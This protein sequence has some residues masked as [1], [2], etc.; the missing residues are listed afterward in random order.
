MA[1]TRFVLRELAG[2]AGIEARLARIAAHPNPAWAPERDG[3]QT[4]ID[5]VSRALF[6]ITEEETRFEVE[7]ETAPISPGPGTLDA[8]RYE[9]AFAFLYDADCDA[10]DLIFEAMGWDVTDGQGDWLECLHAFS[11][12]IICAA[13]GLRGHAPTGAPDDKAV[14]KAASDWGAS[15]AE[16]ARRFRRKG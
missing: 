1:E 12:Q 5:D 9:Q 13:R 3:L 7:T 6:G 16:E 10:A 14:Q 4:A 15:L 8:V 2:I 11:R